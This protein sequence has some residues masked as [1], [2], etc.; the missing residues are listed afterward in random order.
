MFV[1]FVCFFFWILANCG[2]PDL[3][4]TCGYSRPVPNL[5]DDHGLPIEDSTVRFSC[6]PGQ[7]LTGPNSSICMGNGEWEPDPSGLICEGMHRL[8]FIIPYASNCNGLAMY[9]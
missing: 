3:L 7:V 2:N 6:P 9:V 8:K 4:S 5:L 1:F